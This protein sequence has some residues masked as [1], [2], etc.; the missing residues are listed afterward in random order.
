[1]QNL[2]G[3]VLI[4]RFRL[5][6]LEKQD[7]LGDIY[8]GLDVKRN[9]PVAITV[10]RSNLP[11]DPTILSFQ[12]QNITLQTLTHK[13]IAPFYGLYQ[14]QTISFLVERYINGPSLEELLQ[15]RR[16]QPFA[17]QDSIIYLKSLSEA[18]GYVHRFGLVHSNV[19][20]SNI[21][22]DQSG[23]VVLSGFG[24]ARTTDSVMT[25]SGIAG[26][27]AYLAPEEIRRE[28]VTPATDIY[29][30]GLI[31]FEM[32][33]GQHP[34]LGTAR[35]VP[36][37]AA[38]QVISAQL[39]QPPPDPRSLNP[40]IPS[41]FAQVIQTALEK[42]PRGRFQST[43]EMLEVACAVNGSTPDQVPDRLIP[44]SSTD[45]TIIGASPVSRPPLQPSQNAESEA[46][47]VSTPPP[48]VR[49]PAGQPAAFSSTV[50]VP[51]SAAYATPGQPERTFMVEGPPPGVPP[52]E[53]S[54]AYP[55]ES[56]AEARGERK[57]SVMPMAAIIGIGLL[58]ILCAFL[59]GLMAIPKLRGQVYPPAASAT[60]TSAPSAT[61]TSTI[62]PSPV[63]AT[64]VPSN[65]PI[66][67]IISTAIPSATEPPTDTATPPPSPTFTVAPPTTAPSSFKVTIQ[68]NLSFE[69]YAFRDNRLMG[70]DPI[71]PGMYIWYRG[72]PPGQYNFQFCRDQ[73]ATNCPYTKTVNVNQDLTINVP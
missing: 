18:L 4:Q 2:S 17:I 66:P 36:A 8:R 15:E 53:A 56:P 57:R 1:M 51:S 35:N 25:S 58:V 7:D 52:L 42:D 27:P 34:F 49:P 41:G 24:F 38:E 26:I 63:P 45:A 55:E 28:T 12:R 21:S 30:M 32:L 72:I 39:F 43:Q 29:A 47:L 46:T 64:A 3:S 5:D 54:Y 22:V 50:A 48:S 60:H 61:F 6:T 31:L 14:D 71:P 16:G 68:N 20:P 73:K 19:N 40:A 23:L 69:I 70:T 33:T 10:L 37:S 9:L 62:S 13:N 44:P 11:L 59:I 67:A 65:T